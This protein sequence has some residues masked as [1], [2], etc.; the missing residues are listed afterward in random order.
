MTRLWEWWKEN[1]LKFWPIQVVLGSLMILAVGPLAIWLFD[2]SPPIRIMSGALDIQQAKI[3]ETVTT[4]YRV[5]YQR[6]GCTVYFDL[7][8]KDAAGWVWPGAQHV[9]RIIDQSGM[10]DLAF[11]MVIPRKATPG[12][13]DFTNTFGYFCNPLQEVLAPLLT[14]RPL[15]P[16]TVTVAESN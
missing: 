1:C 9:S 14:Q 7:S 4:S 2:N 12:A 15:P 5:D 10:A 13:A 6:L 3:G 16:L 11:P 8:T